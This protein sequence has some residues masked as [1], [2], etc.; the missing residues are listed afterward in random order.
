MAGEHCARAPERAV[1]AINE[2][3]RSWARMRY[4]LRVGELRERLGNTTLRL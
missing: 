1:A 2:D 4:A 3:S